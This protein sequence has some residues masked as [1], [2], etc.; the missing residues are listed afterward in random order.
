MCHAIDEDEYEVQPGKNILR[1]YS[2]GYE[3]KVPVKEKEKLKVTVRTLFSGPFV[4]PKGYTLVSAVYDITM[5]KLSQPATIE[6][7][8]CANESDQT[9]SNLCFAIG[10]VNLKEKKITFEKVDQE[11]NGSIQQKTSCFLCILYKG[12]L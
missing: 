1:D 9:R 7:Q 10:I 2:C 8:H 3:I 6:L 4:Y 5:P 11:F 12:T